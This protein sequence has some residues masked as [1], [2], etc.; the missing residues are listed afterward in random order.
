MGDGEK[1][2]PLIAVDTNVLL[3]LAN[4]DEL[5]IDA[6]E[7]V[8]RRLDGAEFI[9]TP[10]V[11][12]EIA[13]KAESPDTPLDRRL[14]HRVSGSLVYPWGFHPLNFISVRRGIV[15]EVARRIRRE[16]IIP[17][18][19]VNDSLILAEA[20]FVGATLLLS[21]DSH[22]KDIEYARLKIVLDAADVG[23]PLIASP[24]KIVHHFF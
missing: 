23:T 5:V 7:T 4:D 2:S 15:A 12:E 21:S 13:L 19:Q 3:D 18:D 6:L 24:Y 14:A 16:G 20:A 1:K 10:T 11:I 22:L 17:D 9:V 8:R